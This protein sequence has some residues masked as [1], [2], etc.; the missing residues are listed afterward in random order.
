VDLSNAFSAG[1]AYV[2]LSRVTDM[3]GLWMR[4]SLEA[5]NVIVSAEVVAFHQRQ[6]A[7]QQQ[8]LRGGAVSAMAAA[9]PKLTAEQLAKIQ[10]NKEAAIAR[11]CAAAPPKLTAE[12]LA[13]I[14]ANKEA[15]IA[16][17]CALR[18]ARQQNHQVPAGPNCDT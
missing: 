18:V 2:A 4:H 13:K 12:Q 5:A 6:L 9:P 3:K 16:R 1:Q 14:K 8:P 17:R 11:R 10:A 15:A 7:R